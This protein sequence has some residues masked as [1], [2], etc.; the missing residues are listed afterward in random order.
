M[1]LTQEQINS[2]INSENNIANSK[3]EQKVEVIYKDG[4]N[5]HGNNGAKRL[6]EEERI[7]IGVV[8]SVT[9]HQTAS[10][11]FGISKSHVN[12]VKNGN[13]VTHGVRFRDVELTQAIESRLNKT[14]LDI[15]ERA[16]ETLLSALGL[17]S[18]DSIQ[19]KMRNSSPKEIASVTKDMSQVF[20]NMSSDKKGESGP[21]GV[22]IIINAP[23]ESREDSFDVVEIGI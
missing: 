17:F 5:S 10:D 12:D 8:A 22:K 15:Q 13:R 23:K 3:V 7:A 20:R 4:I 1:L 16:A 2:R 21:K 18:D 9:D 11:L 19:D 6:T 14:K